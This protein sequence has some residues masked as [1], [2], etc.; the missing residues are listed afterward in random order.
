MRFEVPQFIEVEDKI[1]G[2]LTWRQFVYVAGGIGLSII[3]YFTLPFILFVIIGVPVMALAGFLAFHRINNRPFSSFL[4][5]FLGYFTRS[6]LYLWKKEKQ[7][8]IVTRREVATPTLPSELPIK[9]SLNS[10]SRKLD[11]NTLQK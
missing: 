9:K 5:S 10:L 4:E 1:V 8:T 2:P 6:R 7:Q 11:F 3:L